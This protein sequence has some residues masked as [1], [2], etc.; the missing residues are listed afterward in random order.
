[1]YGKGLR[2]TIIVSEGT[3]NDGYEGQTQVDRAQSKEMSHVIDRDGLVR[4]ATGKATAKVITIK[5]TVRS[6]LQVLWPSVRTH[7]IQVTSPRQ[8]SKTAKLEHAANRIVIDTMSG[9][10][11]AGGER[12]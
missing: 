1:M 3:L 9:R 2:S 8:F 11:G 5:E 6:Q 7:H 4:T 12:C 10:P